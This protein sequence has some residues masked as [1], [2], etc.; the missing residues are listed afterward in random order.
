MPSRL[1]IAATSD[2]AAQAGAQVADAGGNAVDAAIAALLVSINTEPGMCSLACGGFATIWPPA[3]EPVTLDGYVT[4]PG[5]GDVIPDAERNAWEIHMMYGG[6]ITTAIGPDSVGV[7]GGVALFGAASETYGAVPWRVLFEPAVAAT[8]AGFPLPVASR[9][10]LEHSGE[11]I[12]GRS[13]D[14]RTAL[15]D[16]DGELKRIGETIRIPHLDDTLDR[17]ARNGPQEFYTGAVGRAI[18]KYMRENGGRLNES[19]LAGYRIEHRPSLV[20]DS[21]ADVARRW[22]IATNPPPAVGGTVLAAMLRMVNRE[23]LERWDAATVAKIVDIQRFVLGFR[24]DHLDLADDVDAE[25]QRLLELAA[26]CDPVPALQS[27]STCHASAVDDS[28]LACAITVSSGYSSGDMPDGTGLWLNNCLGE[29][30]LNRRG[31]DIGPPGT[32]LPSNMAPTA[33]RS[34]DGRSLSIGSPGADRITT[35]MLHALVGHLQIGLPLDEAI[36]LP[37]A[38]VEFTEEGVRFA[39]EPGLPVEAASIPHRCFDSLSMYFGGVSAAAWSP[40]DG[41]TVA[42]DPRRTGGTWYRQ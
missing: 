31:L 12:F 15:Y 36:G 5:S 10:Y 29:L 39:C 3:G 19:D 38:H 32:R 6:G 2:L 26:T 33:A 18:A 17:I 25:A 7:P 21:G 13:A 22:Q 34:D 35:A 23:K 16:A 4:A 20:I 30:E 11:P 24:R 1:A 37:R 27:G 8:R 9:H 28:G 42:A 14:G 40:D 41:F